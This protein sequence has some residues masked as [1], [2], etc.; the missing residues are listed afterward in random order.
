MPII[1]PRIIKWCWFA[2]AGSLNR[3]YA[4]CGEGESITAKLLTQRR[5][6]SYK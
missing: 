2:S 6:K 4:Q 5:F 3:G 1:E